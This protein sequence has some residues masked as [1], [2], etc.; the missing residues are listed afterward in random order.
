MIPSVF[1]LKQPNMNQSSLANKQCKQNSSLRIISLLREKAP[2]LVR[3][4]EQCRQ[5]HKPLGGGVDTIQSPPGRN[6]TENSDHAVAS[7]RTLPL[8]LTPG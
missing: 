8:T 1:S 3:W 5:I 4:V 2:A 6:N 7:V